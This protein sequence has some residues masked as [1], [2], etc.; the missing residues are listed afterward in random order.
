M[1]SVS[2]QLSILLEAKMNIEKKLDDM[3]DKQFKSIADKVNITMLVLFALFFAWVMF[4]C[5]PV[6][7]MPW[8][9]PTKF[10]VGDCLRDDNHV[11][12][13]IYIGYYQMVVGKTVEHYVM[14]QGQ[15]GVPDGH[16]IYN[17]WYG[18]DVVPF[19]AGFIH[20]NYTVSK[21]P[22]W[23]FKDPAFGSASN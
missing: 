6:T 18:C 11:Q 23:P 19:S 16:V 12:V 14:C 10:K 21:C 8:S 2:Y 4:G 15:F 3:E 1:N 22:A 17:V 20:R 5:N 9:G 13:S 7:E